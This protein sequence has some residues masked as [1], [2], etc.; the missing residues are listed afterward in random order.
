MLM[1]AIFNF[2]N[3]DHIVFQIQRMVAR[4]T[5]GISLV[6]PGLLS[7][8]QNGSLYFVNDFR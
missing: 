2:E 1:I 6:F 4:R 7:G 3:G 8:F 5:G